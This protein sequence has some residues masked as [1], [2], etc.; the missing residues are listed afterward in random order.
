MPPQTCPTAPR[1]QP[2]PRLD[3]PVQHKPMR[4]ANWSGC[5]VFAFGCSALH[6]PSAPPQ[7][8]LRPGESRVVGSCLVE[9]RGDLLRLCRSAE[10]ENIQSEWDMASGRALDYAGVM[11]RLATF[12]LGSRP[13]GDRRVLMLGLGGG[14]IA[15]DIMLVR[16]LRC[17]HAELP[18]ACPICLPTSLPVFCL[19]ACHQAA[20]VDWTLQVTCV[21]ADSDTAAAAQQFFLPLMFALD[22]C[23][24]AAA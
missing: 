12:A 20:P 11:A 16:A 1:E 5:L 3:Q 9:H 19:P 23:T 14:T 18:C 22:D 6:Q 24:S 8:L 13:R 10:P 2:L 15:A 7:P 17:V 4:S 21:E